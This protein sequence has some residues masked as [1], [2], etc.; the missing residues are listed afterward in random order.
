M[1]AVSTL[2]AKHKTAIRRGDVEIH[3]D[4]AVVERWNRT[5]A[6][7]FFLGINTVRSFCLPPVDRLCVPL[8]E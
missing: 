7:R 2:M 6:E 3:R 5:S 8:S 1:G 4:Q